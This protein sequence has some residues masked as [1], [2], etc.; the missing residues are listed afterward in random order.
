MNRVASVAIHSA[1]MVVAAF[2]VGRVVWVS[3]ANLS[4]HHTLL[5]F[6]SLII[7]SILFACICIKPEEPR[8]WLLVWPGRCGVCHR[9]WWSPC[10]H[11]DPEAGPGRFKSVHVRLK[12]WR[13][14][15]R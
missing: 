1:L 14:R 5:V 9:T 12:P 13:R 3:A 6:C 15:V 4:P 7:G 11:E 10:I 2:L 8:D